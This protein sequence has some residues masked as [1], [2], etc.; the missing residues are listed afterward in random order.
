MTRLK[1]KV[2]IL[3]TFCQ[4]ISSIGFNLNIQFPSGYAEFLRSLSVAGLDLFQFL[5]LSCV[6]PTNF[7]SHLL[8]LTLSL[9]VVWFPMGPMCQSILNPFARTR[10][11]R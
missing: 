9:V 3:I 5:P 7:Y 10:P 2:R 11:P 8:T 4:L 1:S 6:F